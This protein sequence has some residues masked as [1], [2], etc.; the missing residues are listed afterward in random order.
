[1]FRR[2]SYDS[3]EPASYGGYTDSKISSLHEPT[4]DTGHGWSE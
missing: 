4:S 2:P 1:M 3:T